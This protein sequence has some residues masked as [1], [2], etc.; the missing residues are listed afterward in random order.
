MNK[1][2]FMAGFNLIYYSNQLIRNVETVLLDSITI[3]NSFTENYCQ[4]HTE[5][6]KRQNIFN[7]G[8]VFYMKGSIGP[9]RANN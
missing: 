7:A 1:L 9:F 8:N 3:I 6:Y 5:V 2:N 4:Y